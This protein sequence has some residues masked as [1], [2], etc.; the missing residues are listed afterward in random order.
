MVKLKATVSRTVKHWEQLV[1]RLTTAVKENVKMALG[2]MSPA[3]LPAL[4]WCVS[5]QTK[6]AVELTP[7]VK[8][9]SAKMMLGQR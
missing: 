4:A 2:L 3:R 6:I 8:T 5:V 9:E 1:K 7:A